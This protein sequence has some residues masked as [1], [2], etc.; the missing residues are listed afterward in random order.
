MGRTDEIYERLPTIGQHAAVTAFG[1]YWAWAR[2]GPG[3]RRHLEA[4]RSRERWTAAEWETYRSAATRSL[5]TDAVRNVPHY[6]S[7]YTGTDREAALAGQLD[8]LPLLE[9]AP[10]RRDPKAFIDPR[11]VPPHPKVF[12]TSGSTGTPVATYWSADELRASMALREVR[13]A[14]WAGTSFGRPRATFSGRMVEPDPESNGPYYRLNAIERQ[15]YLSPFHLS[16]ATAAAYADAFRRHRIQWATGYAVSFS[17]L[18]GF[19]LDEGIEPLSL[20]AVVT[21]SEKLTDSMRDRISAAFGCRVYEEYS[22]VENAL[23]ASEC[24]HGSL[25]VSPDAGLV[26]ILRPDGSPADPGET[27]EVVA[28][29]LLR[30]VQPLIRYRL[31][32][33][34]SWS[35]EP[36]LCG[37]NLPVIAE[38]SGRVEDV[39]VGPDGRELVRFHGVFV[40]IPGV[41]EAQV[42]QETLDRF[43]VVVVPDS[44]FT[45]DDEGEMIR[46][47]RQRLGAVSVAVE[48]AEGIPRTASGKFRAV[49]SE[50][51]STDDPPAGGV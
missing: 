33:L 39:L 43:R 1:S 24:E 14:G 34:A 47:M 17:L 6:R 51:T 10:L 25:H 44:S 16:R 48:R 30:K 41:V 18:A 36:C 37:R 31:G 32:D 4:F 35:A 2:F 15:I 7:T 29:C 20:R 45:A 46:R 19:I 27:G 38:V 40:G 13:S 50:I 12:H 9:K 5:L 26:E 11:L 49:V 28:T 8:E 23:F 22:T 42:V 21:T 3:F